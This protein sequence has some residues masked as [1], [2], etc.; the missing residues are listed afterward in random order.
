MRLDHI[1]IVLD[2]TDSRECA[3]RIG[4]LHDVEQGRLV[5]RPT[6]PVTA[7]S[8]ARDVLQALGK[9]LELPESPPQRGSSDLAGV[10]LV[11]EDIRHAY[12]LRAH[13]LDAAAVWQILE[14]AHEVTHVWLVLATQELPPAIGDAI[15][16][17][18]AHQ[19]RDRPPWA[20]R[21]PLDLPL[22]AP[23]LDVRAFHEISDE[24]DPRPA[25]APATALTS[26]WPPVPEHD[27]FW[28]FRSSARVLLSDPDFDRIDD[29]LHLGRMAAR[30]WIEQRS[31]LLQAR[32]GRTEVDA[33]LTGLLAPVTSRAQA[34]TRIRGAQC[35]FFLAGTLVEVPAS[36]L[37]LSRRSGC[38]P[39]DGHA[40]EILRGFAAPQ[41]AAAGALALACQLPPDVICRLALMDL[42]RRAAHVAVG[43]ARFSIPEHAR[44]L[45]RAQ[46]VARTQ[47]G[48]GGFDPLFIEPRTS[49][50]MSSGRMTGMLKRISRCTGL[51]VLSDRCVGD[52]QCGPVPWLA[53]E[54]VKVTR[55]E[56]LRHLE[57]Q[58]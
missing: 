33:F 46:H 10:W 32:F 50:A 27:E 5:V 36:A 52:N 24:R 43:R 13:L 29:E 23:E 40:V 39:L 8:L 25:P 31:E 55:L 34:L 12:V 21:R 6:P 9:R 51:A 26:P 54:T 57:A 17:F 20:Q 11:A 3:E 1:H 35:A 37:A 45:V 28:T 14:I 30:D 15:P 58:A 22:R 4:A 41:M 53:A 47:E 7:Q 16:N 42:G 2:A 56:S 38:A 48:A 44:S 19:D 49:S 18:I